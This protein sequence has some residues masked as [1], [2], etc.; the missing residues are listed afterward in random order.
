[1]HS[2]SNPNPGYPEQ[3]VA[4]ETCNTEMPA[5]N[6][7]TLTDFAGHSQLARLEKALCTSKLSL[8]ALYDD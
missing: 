8:C 4:D 7:L 6:P 3:G 1:V 2:P 5:A